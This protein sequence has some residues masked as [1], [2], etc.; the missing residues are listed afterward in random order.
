MLTTN[1]NR[2]FRNLC[3]A[4]FKVK[5]LNMTNLWGTDLVAL[6]DGV[7]D[8]CRGLHYICNGLQHRGGRGKDAVLEGLCGGG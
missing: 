7:L 4:C 2:E 3:I 6:W 1:F 5:I 8:A